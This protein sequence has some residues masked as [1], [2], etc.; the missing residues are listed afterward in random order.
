MPKT[1]KPV[2]S[3]ADRTVLLV[4]DI[5][6]YRR[7]LARILQIDHGLD[8]LHVGSTLAALTVLENTAVDAVVADW[9]LGPGYDGIALLEIVHHR[10]PGT[11]RMLLTADT[12][13]EMVVTLPYV[14]LDK[15]LAGWLI[16]QQIADLVRAL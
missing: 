14:V 9:H 11:R 8:V 1:A 2:R 13:G 10:W 5:P 15:G 16:S 3:P 4:D 12:T 7:N 6:E